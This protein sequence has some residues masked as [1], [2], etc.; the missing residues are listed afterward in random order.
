MASAATDTNLP[1]TGEQTGLRARAEML[2][3]GIDLVRSLW[4]GRGGAMRERLK[5]GPPGPSDQ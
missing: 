1:D 5:A 2:D 3:D 4:E